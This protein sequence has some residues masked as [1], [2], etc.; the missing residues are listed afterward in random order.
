MQLSKFFGPTAPED[1]AK[2]GGLLLGVAVGWIVCEIANLPEG[3]FFLFAILSMWLMGMIHG[4]IDLM[5][6]NEGKP[7]VAL[8]ALFWRGMS[9]AALGFVLMLAIEGLRAI[10]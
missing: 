2:I 4:A 5:R 8:R 3:L 9:E 10:T 7:P 6:A 1:K